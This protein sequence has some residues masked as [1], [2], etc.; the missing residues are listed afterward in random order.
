MIT[1]K[2][3]KFIMGRRKKKRYPAY[4]NVEI[5][6]LAIE[7]KAVAKVKTEIF[8]DGKKETSEMTIFVN[9]VVPGDI[10]DV[11]IN[12]KKRNYRE[13]YPVNFHKY[14]EK[15]IE[16]FCEHFG[17][18]GGCTRQSISYE[19]QLFYKQKQ[20]KETLKRIGKIDFE[21][22]ETIL[23][24]PETTFY[25]NKLEY[26]FSDSRWL[27]DADINTNN[28]IKNRNALG[29]HIPGRFDK[30]IDIKK[31][32]LQTES[33]NKIRLW[34]KDF[35]NKN[36]YEFFNLRKQTGL[37]R[38]L[39]IR[40]A[41]T[42]DIMVIV[43]FFKKD[44]EKILKLLE[45]L[46]KEFPEI[47]SLMYVINPKKNDTITDLKIE[48]FK[49][50]DHIMETMEE[51]KFKV[52]AKSF[53][54][55]N[56]KQAYNLYKIVR[57]FAGLTGKEIVYDLYTGTGTIANFLASNA[58]KIIGI[59]YVSEAINDAKINSKLNKINNTEFYAGMMKDI[60]NKK[61]ITK[62][63]KPDVIILDPPRAGMH[64]NVVNI[65]LETEPEKIVYVSCNPATQARDIQLMNEKYELLRTKPVDMFP[66]THHTENVVLLHK[67]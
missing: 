20:I 25:R 58:K 14:S 39:I 47:S 28:E 5:I 2:K 40:T 3:I 16:P 22:L 31:C 11:Q 1:N 12:K 44:T 62:T 64:K 56:S 18:C 19:D 21:E 36:K 17:T 42:G 29:F 46:S 38:N 66:H 50:K 4:K 7:G 33:S 15:R 53:Y 55:T 37:L 27:T 32:W 24:A 6:D 8:V 9:K 41:T 60:L 51:L 23:P 63:G 13:G 61:F 67:K 57:E 26:T 59:E 48:L 10:V 35:A 45:K 34:I 49:G 43:S 54:Q 65:I 30:V 52:G